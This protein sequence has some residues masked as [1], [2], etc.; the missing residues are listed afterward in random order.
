MKNI[1]LSF[2]VSSILIGQFLFLSTAHANEQLYKVNIVSS[3]TAVKFLRLKVQTQDNQLVLTGKVKR[4][5]RNTITLPGHIDVV[6]TDSNGQ[7]LLEKKVKYVPA[8][9]SRRSRFGS[10]FKMAL[11][12][13]IPEG[14]SIKVQWHKNQATNRLLSTSMTATH[15]KV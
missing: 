5:S 14:S 11:P 12:N 6:V 10:S 2:A 8:I 3:T 1:I 7:I 13:N 9:L 15:N 4:R